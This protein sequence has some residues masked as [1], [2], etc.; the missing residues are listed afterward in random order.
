[1]LTTEAKR[2]LHKSDMEVVFHFPANAPLLQPVQQF[3]RTLKQC[4]I[5]VTEGYSCAHTDD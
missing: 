1:M 4:V 3:P 5:A 2:P